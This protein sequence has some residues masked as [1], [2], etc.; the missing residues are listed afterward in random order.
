MAAKYSRRGRGV[1]EK[2]GLADDTL[3]RIGG[4]GPQP[5]GEQPYSVFRDP[6]TGRGRQ[7]RP[8]VYG[9]ADPTALLSADLR[10][11]RGRAVHA[12]RSRPSTAA[13]GLAITAQAMT[14]DRPSSFETDMSVWPARHGREQRPGLPAAGSRP[15][16]I[17]VVELARLLHRERT[18]H[19]EA[20]RLTP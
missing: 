1:Q 20:L 3:A 17:K 16:D 10:R 4:E 5:R 9:P 6:I 2:Y 13:R 11:G 7:E 15:E 12:G 8:H 14:T 19:Y 18:A